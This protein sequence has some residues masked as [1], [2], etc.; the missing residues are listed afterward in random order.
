MTRQRADRAILVRGI[1]TLRPPSTSAVL[2]TSHCDWQAC[3]SLHNFLVIC[4]G[5]GRQDL[6]DAAEG[7]EAIETAAPATESLA[8]H[9]TTSS[10]TAN[11]WRQGLAEAMHQQYTR[12]LDER[13]GIEDGDRLD[14]V[15]AFNDDSLVRPILGT[16]DV[17]PAFRTA[18]SLWVPAV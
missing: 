7:Y 5:H 17:G 11:A 8:G 10:T 4:R 16:D 13:D 12:Y 6:A 14:L 1:G 9:T 2:L 15:E 3:V 18:V